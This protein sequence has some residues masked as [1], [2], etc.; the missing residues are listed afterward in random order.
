MKEKKLIPKSFSLLGGV[1]RRVGGSLSNQVQTLVCVYMC[2]LH[3]FVN[4]EHVC[5]R[6]IFYTYL[7][8]CSSFFKNLVPRETSHKILIPKGLQYE[9]GT[10]SI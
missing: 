9:H 10:F 2:F 3:Q 5:M 8:S 7:L 4:I 6:V 1:E